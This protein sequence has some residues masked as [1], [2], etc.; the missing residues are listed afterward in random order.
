MQSNK[1]LAQQSYESQLLGMFETYFVNNADD[2]Q[3]AKIH[4]KDGLKRA[5]EAYE[6]MLDVI[7]TYGAQ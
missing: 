4:L 6:D 2:E 7:D 1:E 3:K 5:K